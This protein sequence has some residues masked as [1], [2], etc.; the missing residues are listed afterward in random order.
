MSPD[1]LAYRFPTGTEY[2]TGEVPKEGDVVTNGGER[3]LVVEV[4]E[5]EVSSPCVVTLKAFDPAES[6]GT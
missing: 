2:R 3:W 4:T 6:S 1:M 5:S